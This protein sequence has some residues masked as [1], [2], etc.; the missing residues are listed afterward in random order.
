[1]RQGK[2]KVSQ[3][4][5]PPLAE[6]TPEL[7]QASSLREQKYGRQVPAVG[8]DHVGFRPFWSACLGDD[9]L[10]LTARQQIPNAGNNSEEWL[11]FVRPI[12][13]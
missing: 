10:L 7:T 5:D 8:N 4:A 3:K 6:K 2:A 1:V 13:G 11:T 9:N 12:V